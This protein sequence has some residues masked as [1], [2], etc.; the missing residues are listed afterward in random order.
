MGT[1]TVGGAEAVKA[2]V[3]RCIAMRRLA[4]DLE[5]PPLR[6]R[7]PIT[8]I[9]VRQAARPLLPCLDV[10]AVPNCVLSSSF[11]ARWEDDEPHASTAD[12]A[13]TANYAADDDAAAVAL[14]MFC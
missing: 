14:E 5:Q 6:A 11:C 2:L 7:R 4:Q 1:L 13:A 12:D 10:A 3:A 8:P 9:A